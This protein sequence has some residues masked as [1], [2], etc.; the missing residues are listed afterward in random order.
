MVVE[1]DD[2]GPAV[3]FSG[4]EVTVTVMLSIQQVSS[5]PSWTHEKLHEDWKTNHHGQQG[6]RTCERDGPRALDRLLY[7]SIETGDRWD[8]LAYLERSHEPQGWQYERLCW[9]L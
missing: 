6:H 7:L 9:V 5:D 4:I 2:S 3:Q 1:M 8:E